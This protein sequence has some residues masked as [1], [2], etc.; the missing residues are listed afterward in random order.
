MDVKKSNGFKEPETKA[1]DNSQ[2][3]GNGEKTLFQRFR[4]LLSLMTIEPMMVVQGIASNIS[5]FPQDQMILYK[6]CKEPQFNLTDDFCNNIEENTNTTSY[7]DVEAE[8]V[9]FNNVITLSEHLVP[10]LLSFYIGSWSDHYGRKPFLAFCMVGKVIGA[11]F[12][13]LNAIYL[14]EWN[15][16]VWVATVM[17]IQNISGGFLAFIMMTYSFISDNSTRRYDTNL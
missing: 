4:M 8:V 12:N 14:N 16:W 17:P 9:S 3:A 15:R 6:I 7:D 10:I 13:L 1:Y 5:M 2:N 11:T